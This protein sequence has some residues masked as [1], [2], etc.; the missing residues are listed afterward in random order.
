MPPRA[1]ENKLPDELVLAYLSMRA[2]IFAMHFT[3]R[4][5]GLNAREMRLISDMYIYIIF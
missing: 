3:S 4:D 2:R 1:K 5:V